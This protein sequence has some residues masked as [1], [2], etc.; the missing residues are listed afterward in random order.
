[1]RRPIRARPKPFCDLAC[2]SAAAVFFV[3]GTSVYLECRARQ[4]ILFKALGMASASSL[5]QCPRFPFH[6]WLP[7]FA[8]V[9][10]F[11]L[12]FCALM[13]RRI[14][15]IVVAAACW[16]FA[17]VLWELRSMAT[18][19]LDWPDVFAACLGFGTAVAVAAVLMRLPST[20]QPG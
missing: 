6:W 20:M 1:M 12:A 3:L 10:A 15:S 13:P 18:G 11:S 17:N 14:R 9:T 4:P 16:T 8:H 19:T 2:L 5:V 7:T